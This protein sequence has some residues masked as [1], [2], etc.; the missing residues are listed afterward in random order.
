MPRKPAGA[1]KGDLPALELECMKVLWEG[2]AELSVR[3]VRERLLPSRALAYTTV[4]T[5][6][7]RLARKGA[8]TRRKFGRAHL[9]LASY[10]RAAARER[11]VARLLDNYFGG[12]R[13]LL[14]DHL[15]PAARPATG[16][17]P[18]VPARTPAEATLRRARARAAEETAA[19]DTALL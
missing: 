10:S 1:W 12:S 6:L 13:D 19:L 15:G 9:Y 17:A 3:D 18:P 8:A 14:L 7:D 11:A 2:A 5:L 16:G 4:L